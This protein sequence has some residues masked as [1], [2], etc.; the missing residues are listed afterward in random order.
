[1][2]LVHFFKLQHKFV[3]VTGE[4]VVATINNIVIEAMHALLRTTDKFIQLNIKAILSSSQ[5]VPV[6]FIVINLWNS[7]LA[8]LRNPTGSKL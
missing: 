8:N 2:L 6:I 5:M 4:Y 7:F 3:Q 1:M